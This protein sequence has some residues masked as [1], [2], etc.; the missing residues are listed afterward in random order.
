MSIYTHASARNVTSIPAG[1]N[2]GGNDIVGSRLPR[3]MG[4]GGKTDRRQVGYLR[5]RGSRKGQVCLFV[6][7]AAACVR[8]CE[9]VRVVVRVLGQVFLVL[10]S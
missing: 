7:I 3:A 6:C 5:F 9:S 1:G 4:A 2:G 10:Q 8:A